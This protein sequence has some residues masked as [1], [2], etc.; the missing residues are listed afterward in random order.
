MGF[1]S[2]KAERIFLNFAKSHQKIKVNAGLCRFN[3][4][5]QINAVN[6]AILNKET[7]VALCFTVRGETVIIHFVNVSENGVFTDNTLGY[8]TAKYEYYFVKFIE[9]EDFMEIDSVF[10]AYRE[11]LHDKL[12]FLIRIF[13]DLD[14]V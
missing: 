2:N 6:D 1:I 4:K 11:M 7:R 3:Y 14:I 5:C 9:E 10:S 13:T 8:Y 12:P